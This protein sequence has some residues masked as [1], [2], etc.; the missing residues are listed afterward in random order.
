MDVQERAQDRRDRELA[1][2]LQKDEG[3]DQARAAAGGDSSSGVGQQP[4][5]ELAWETAGAGN[6]LGGSPPA[7]EG[8]LSAEEG[9]RKAFEA[10]ERRQDN[11]AGM[12]PGK[13]REMNERQQKDE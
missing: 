7:Q 10:A 5:P 9:K 3:E 13:G 2:R 12:A 11:V 4:K 8:E 6:V 1:A